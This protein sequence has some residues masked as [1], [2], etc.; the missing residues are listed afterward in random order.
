ME[1]ACA[2]RAEG[3][4]VHNGLNPL[5][6]ELLPD[7]HGANFF[8]LEVD[9]HTGPVAGRVNQDEQEA[10]LLDFRVFVC[11][12]KRV[13]EPVVEVGVEIEVEGEV[14]ENR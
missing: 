7:S 13:H 14:N 2:A 3:R 6:R 1:R 11:G 8:L 5:C 12:P 4:T 10:I 9:T